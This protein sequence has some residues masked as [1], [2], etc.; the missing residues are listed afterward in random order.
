MIV[1]NQRSKRK[2]KSHVNGNHPYNP[3]VVFD[4]WRRWIVL[5]QAGPLGTHKDR[6]REMKKVMMTETAEAMMSIVKAMAN[7][8][9][10]MSE[11]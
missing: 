2:E 6:R 10:P 8:R 4:L 3:C 7:R 5:E 1:R 9:D 11:S